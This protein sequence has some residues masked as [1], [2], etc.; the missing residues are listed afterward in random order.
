MSEIDRLALPFDQYQRY[1]AAAQVADL[2]RHHLGRPSLDVLDV[3]G[4]Y[5]TRQGHAILPL[6]HFLPDDQTVSVDLDAEPLSNYLVANGGALP[7]GRAFDLVVSCDTLE[8]VA[9][10]KRPGFVDELVRVTRHAL[11]LIAPFDSESV[12]LAEHLLVEYMAAHGMQQPQLKEHA[13]RGL[14]DAEGLRERL[15]QRGLASLD[16]P[17]GYLHHWLAMMLIKHTPG[18]S[19]NF[20]LDLDRYYNLHFSPSDRRDPAY[21]RTFVVVQPGDEALLP[22]VARAWNDAPSSPD[23]PDLV[24]ELL[25]FLNRDQTEDLHLRLTALEAQNAD[26]RQRIE[27]FERGRFMQVMRWLHRHRTRPTARTLP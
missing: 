24:R 21:R 19:L 20:H 10:S 1:S 25:R 5:R 14:P 11:V 7:F 15:A 2:L 4:L 27:D 18:Y 17:D 23:R 8:H 13:E 26:L 12:R 3:G 9:E 6:A 22:A 16:L